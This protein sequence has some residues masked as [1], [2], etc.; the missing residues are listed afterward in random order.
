LQKKELE[1]KGYKPLA[2]AVDDR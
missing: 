1:K 2:T